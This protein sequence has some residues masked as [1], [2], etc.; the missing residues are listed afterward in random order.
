MK[1][2]LFVALLAAAASLQAAPAFAQPTCSVTT[3]SSEYAPGDPVAITGTGG[4]A[5]EEITIQVI[6]SAS[7]AVVLETTATPDESGAF[8]TTWDTTG[9]APGSYFV[10]VVLGDETLCI[11][12]DFAIVAPSEPP[13]PAPDGEGGGGGGGGGSAGGGGGEGCPCPE[14]EGGSGGAATPS[15]SGEL[16]FTG[17]PLVIVGGLGLVLMVG[18]VALLRTGKP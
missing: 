7:G 6:E 16:P 3:D 8:G 5:D 11:S 10:Q 1:K 15:P 12:E 13:P 9:A 4:P 14:G 2:L 18:G 17:V